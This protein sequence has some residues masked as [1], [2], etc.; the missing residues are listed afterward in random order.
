[1]ETNLMQDAPSFAE[2]AAPSKLLVS[3]LGQKRSHGSAGDLGFRK[4]L[5]DY[6]R[7][8][9]Q[10]S[11]GPQGNIIVVVGNPTHSTTLFSCHVDTV[12]GSKE[13]NQPLTDG[14][15][16]RL[17]YDTAFEH[18]FLEDKTQSGCLGADDGAGIYVLLRMIEAEVP[19]TYVFHV[20]EEKGG[21]GS[22][23]L[24]TARKEWLEGFDRAIAFDRK[25]STDV[26]THQGGQ[27]CASKTFCLDLAAALD[28]G[29]KPSDGGTFTDTKVY[30]GVIPEC[31][32]VA[33]GYENAHTPAEYLD[34]GYLEHLVAACIKVQW[35][36]LPTVRKP[37]EPAPKLSINDPWPSHT[38]FGG[39][40]KGGM[41]GAPAPAKPTLSLNKTSV[42]LPSL[43]DEVLGMDYEE[44]LTFAEEDPVIAADAMVLL[45]TQLDA[46]KARSKSLMRFVGGGV[47]DYS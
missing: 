35:D 1:M 43:L 15:H 42:K 37:V 40:L 41:S 10:V 18:V 12:H 30:A 8:Q 45:I 22:R 38:L 27:E 36:K 29:H 3:I 11:V 47:N 21:I 44:L 34:Y 17:M 39:P 16:Q 23:A 46:E 7:N 19:G 14:Y 9:K 13:S 20:G 5:L 28:M 32:N 31:T 2:G 24:L 33:C 25:G 6:L 4:W 26:I